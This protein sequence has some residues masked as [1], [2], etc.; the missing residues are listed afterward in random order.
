MIPTLF[1]PLVFVALRSLCGSDNESNY[2]GAVS[3]V[4]SGP[5]LSIN[6]A[7]PRHHILYFI[8]FLYFN[9]GYLW[10]LYEKR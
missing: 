8:Y 9:N 5:E 6:A 1:I 4:A 2:A 10:S 3:A 7:R